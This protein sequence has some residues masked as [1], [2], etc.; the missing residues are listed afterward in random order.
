MKKIVVSFSG[1]RTSAYMAYK[2]QFSPEFADFEKHYVFANTGKELEET[3][4]FVDKCDKEFEL[5]LTWVEAVFNPVKGIGVTYKKVDYNTASR[6]GEPFME[7]IKKLGIPNQNFP[8][9]SREL[10][11][12]P[13][14]KWANDAVG[15]NRFMAIG[16]RVDERRR[17]KQDVNNIY[18][19]ITTWP[20]NEKMVRE[21]W[22]RMP[23]DLGIKDYHGNCDLCWKKSLAKR[24]TILSEN[25][26]IGDQ[27]EQ[28]E[29][30]SEYVFDRDG[31]TISDLRQMAKRPF[32]KSTDKHE[33]RQQFPE[34]DFVDMF[35]ESSCTCE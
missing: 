27:W 18:P 1:G 23:F 13:I 30:D 25:P 35:R 34:L 11:A 12:R 21:F 24:L 29:N 26:S 17:A 2:M 19:L 22:S 14:N 33:M 7:M 10:K 15:R 4:I 31:F 8:H 5:N 28:W 6:N 32:K 9:C 3:L 20:T 16:M